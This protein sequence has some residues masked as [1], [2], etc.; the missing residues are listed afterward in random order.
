NIRAYDPAFSGSGD[1]YDTS[2]T[3]RPVLARVPIAPDPLTNPNYTLPTPTTSSPGVAVVNTNYGDV[4]VSNGQTVTLNP[5][6]YSSIKVTGGTVTFNPGIYVLS[7]PKNA[8][9]TF[10]I[11]G[12]TLTGNGVMFYNTGSDYTPSSGAPDSSDGS[13][14]PNAPNS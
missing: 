6:I 1:Y 5:G 4:N 10:Q 3:D 12:G 8:T 2:N 7:P 9:N 14:T 13:A 11:S